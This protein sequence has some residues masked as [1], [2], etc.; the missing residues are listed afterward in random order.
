MEVF[1]A[2]A[3]EDFF[4]TTAS[5]EP[6]PALDNLVASLGRQG[7]QLTVNRDTLIS[8]DLIHTAKNEAASGPPPLSPLPTPVTIPVDHFVRHLGRML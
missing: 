6:G 3:D 4:W 8:Y 5:Q 1:L 2:S 7:F